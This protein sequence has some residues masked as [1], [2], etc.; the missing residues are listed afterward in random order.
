[1]SVC[2]GW[3]WEGFLVIHWAI[4]YSKKRSQSEIAENSWKKWMEGRHP[5]FLLI[6]SR[7]T[8][9][10][11][12][13]TLPLSHVPPSLNTPNI[14]E[15]IY[16]H[17]G[18]PLH[19]LFL[20]SPYPSGQVP[21]LIWLPVESLPQIPKPRWSFI[22]LWSHTIYFII[23]LIIHPYAYLHSISVFE[24]FEKGHNIC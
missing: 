7:N 8:T 17:A 20:S 19:T 3:K 9:W 1:M 12:G 10:A 14:K 15:T 21:V 13:P 23:L 18:T 24:R 2:V 11:L 5:G 6:T 4:P 22:F 16:S